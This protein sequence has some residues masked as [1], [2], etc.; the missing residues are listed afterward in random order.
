[1]MGDV[2]HDAIKGELTLLLQEEGLELEEVTQ[3]FWSRDAPAS[4]I[5]GDKFIVLGMKTKNLE[6]TQWLMLP[7][8]SSVG[9]HRTWIVELTLRSMFGP[10]LLRIQRSVGRRLVTKNYRALC[11]NN[12]IVRKK[13][14]E[15][16]VV[17]RLKYFIDVSDKC[18]GK[19]PERVCEKIEKLHREMDK[20]RL[21][22]EKKSVVR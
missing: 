15:H 6:V 1:M 21:H 9:D 5:N 17:Q 10:N 2:N 16:N 12:A 19:P 11:N 14:Q 3:E 7:W 4:H 22:A 20:L 18:N 8:M 13:Y